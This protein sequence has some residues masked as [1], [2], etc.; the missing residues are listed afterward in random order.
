M[1]VDSTT[2]IDIETVNGSVDLTF[3]ENVSANLKVKK[4]LTERSLMRISACRM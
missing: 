2:G 1:D 3:G 4:L